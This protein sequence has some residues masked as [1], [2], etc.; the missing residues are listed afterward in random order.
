MIW[1]KDDSELTKMGSNEVPFITV[2]MPV[3]NE[4]LFIEETLLQ[5]LTQNYPKDKFEIII[6]DSQSDDGTQQ[7]VNRLAREHSRTIPKEN[8]MGIVCPGRVQVCLPETRQSNRGV[9]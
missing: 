5:I 3:R 6:A 7:V 1:G 4:A 9:T 8:P 2:C